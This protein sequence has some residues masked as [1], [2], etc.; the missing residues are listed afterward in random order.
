MCALDRRPL[1][2]KPL[3]ANPG[4]VAEPQLIHL[5]ACPL[6][7]E[8]AGHKPVVKLRESFN[9]MAFFGGGIFAVILLNAGRSKRVQCNACREIFSIREPLSIISLIAFWL[10]IAPIALSLIAFVIYLLWTFA[11][12]K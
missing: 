1:T 5:D 9:W 8:F 4:S 3:P 11:T 7:G 10:L 6:C 12:G 2:V